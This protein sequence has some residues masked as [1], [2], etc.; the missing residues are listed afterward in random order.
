MG[1][2][3]VELGD[4]VRPGCHQQVA[5]Q[6]QV[7]FTGRNAHGEQILLPR[8]DTDMADHRTKFL[9]KARLIEHAAAFTF[10]VRSVTQHRADGGDPGTAD[11]RQQDVVRLVEVRQGR[12]WQLG[13]RLRL[14]GQLRLAQLAAMHRHEAGTEAFDAAEVL[15]NQGAAF[16]AAAFFGG[17]GLVI[18]DHRH[19]FEFPQ[20]A[21]HAVEV[22]AVVERGAVAEILEH[23]GRFGE[24]RLTNPG[25]A[26]AA[27][28]GKRVGFPVHPDGHVMAADAGQ[29]A[30]PF[31]DPCR[32]VELQ[33]GFDF[34]AAVD[35]GKS[36][37][38]DPGDHRGRQFGQIGQQRTALFVELADNTRTL[39]NGPV[40]QLAGQLILDHAAFFLDHENFF[41]TLG[42]AMHRDWFQRPAHADLEHADA[43]RCAE[44]FVDAELFQ[45][46]AHVQV[47]LAGGDDAQPRLWRIDHHFVEVV[48]PRKRPR[49][50][51]FVGVE[52]CLLGK[53]RI[54]PANVQAA[55]GNLEVF[56]DAG[57]DAQR[58]DFNH[59]GRIDV[60]RNGLHRHPA[61]AVARE[62]PADDAVIENFLDIAR[63]EH[64]DHRGDER[65]F[66]LVRDGRRFAAV[67]VARE[68]QHPAVFRYAGR[69]AVF[70][71]VPATVD[72]RALAV[73]EGEHA[74]I[75]AVGEQVDLLTAPYRS[76]REFFVD[77]G[78]EM[79]GVL[80]EIL[81]GVPQAL[82]EIAQRRAPVAGDKPGG[83]Q[84]AGFIALLLQ[85]RQPGQGLR[86]GQCLYELHLRLAIGTVQPDGHKQNT[87]CPAQ[88]FS[89]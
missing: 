38:D 82:V 49:R 12:L 76:G 75:F 21:L 41:K 68:D 35:R 89:F 44:F 80:L 17:A 33:T 31:R 52:P 58:V 10:Q 34:R 84:A 4:G 51:D 62:L 9:R 2:R 79:N 67:V 29:R 72:A 50:I 63:V 65:V 28:L 85:H 61:T 5:T 22:A 69:V 18:D 32:R 74:V 47:G 42:E 14:L 60:F 70:E 57:L 71:D 88:A 45:R 25:H 43:H 73:P 37:G 36:L 77:A 55:L 6:Q 27:H 3:A 66:A 86:S 46:L 56:R 11:S 30:T 24:R 83:V 16:A 8:S 54:R 26:L 87:A 13:E 81:L 39:I 23:V 53:G 7:C 40:V 19:A 15:I 1:F 48:G 78:L 20:L 64:R 59:R